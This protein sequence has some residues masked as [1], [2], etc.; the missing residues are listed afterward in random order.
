MVCHVHI[1]MKKFQ[2]MLI[3]K[4][5][6]SKNTPIIRTNSDMVQTL[7][8]PQWESETIMIIMLRC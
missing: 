2:D 1:S 6:L 7:E 5:N 8:F 4:K 3:D